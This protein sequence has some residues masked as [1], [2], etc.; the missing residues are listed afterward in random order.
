VNQDAIIKSKTYWDNIKKEAEEARAKLDPDDTKTK[1]KWDEYTKKIAE[2]DAQLKKWET[3]GDSVAAKAQREAKEEAKA[4][5]R[6]N[7]ELLEMMR[8]AQA[9]RIALMEDEEQK[10]MAKIEDAYTNEI[11]AIEKKMAEWS[12]AQKGPLTVEQTGAYDEMYQVAFDK[13]MKAEADFY[14]KR[15]EKAAEAN[16]EYLREYGSY[17]EKILGINEYYNKKIAEAKSDEEK[18]LLN[19]QRDRDISETNAE[20]AKKSKLWQKFFGD[21]EKLG[22]KSVREMIA[23][24]ELLL[25]YGNGD[26]KELPVELAESF[27]G[28]DDGSE[29]SQELIKELIAQLEKLRKTERKIDEVNPFRRIIDGFD[30]LS[31]AAGDSGKEMDAVKNILSGFGEAGSI[32]TELGQA[33]EEAGMKAGK[34]V[35][36]I[37]DVIS[38]AVSMAGAGASI[39]QGWGAVIGAVVGAASALIPALAGSKGLSEE[40]RHY[41]ES[42]IEVTDEL[43][44]KQLQLVDAAAGATAKVAAENAKLLNELKRERVKEALDTYLRDSG[45]NYHSEGY[46]FQKRLISY[47]TSNGKILNRDLFNA[48]YKSMVNAYG[49]SNVKEWDLLSRQLEFGNL[50]IVSEFLDT[51]ELEKN[52][53]KIADILRDTA[54]T[55]T[56][57]TADQLRALKTYG[58]EVWSLLDDETQKYLDSIIEIDD[59][60]REIERRER[61]GLTGTTEEAVSGSLDKLYAEAD[62]TFEKIGE[63]FEEHIKKAI[64]NMVSRD[65]LGKIQDWYAGFAKDMEDGILDP[66]EA[67]SLRKKYKE[68]AESGNDT[69]QKALDLIGITMGEAS[70]MSPLAGAIKGASQ[71]EINALTG[72]M[73]NTM[74]NQRE[75]TELIRDQ[76]MFL[77]NI[78]GK[79]GVSNKFLES[80]DGKLTPKS[81]PLRAMGIG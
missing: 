30:D 64:L 65:S 55:L 26:L 15:D 3:S 16:N 22:K 61:E 40:T 28:L 37:G 47:I 13:R 67:E 43:I 66:A 36:A 39:G 32:F 7:E 53:I 73:N 10:E 77:A 11:A 79:L 8:K 51:A 35:V 72:Y 38:K 6:R 24:I 52:G 63:S 58:I 60:I 50:K 80:I 29:K 20:L 4:I 62:L 23:Q 71:E 45:W 46:E 34:V 74:I 49:P 59:Y 54:G 12:E 57:Y 2:A 1:A 81:D 75:A 76:L 18:K 41:Y 42:L 69:Y 78:D 14:K 33:M 9:D 21:L 70:S 27:A 5:K 56:T 19:A 31:K 44:D 25:Q 68:I 48:A 17:Q